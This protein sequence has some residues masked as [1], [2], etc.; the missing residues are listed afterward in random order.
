MLVVLKVE[1]MVVKMVEHWV[2]MLFAWRVD[3][4]VV[5]KVYHIVLLKG[6][7]DCSEDG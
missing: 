4:M 5:M 7:S 1:W 2:E 6:T 3:K